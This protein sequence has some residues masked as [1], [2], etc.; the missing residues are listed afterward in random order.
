MKENLKKNTRHGITFLM[1]YLTVSLMACKDDNLSSG[2]NPSN[3]V[4]ITKIDPEEGGVGTQCLIYG[5]NFGTDISKIE[6]TFNGKKANIVG[7]D[8]DCV[9]CFVPVRAGSGPIKVRVGDKENIQEA[10]A[11]SE[12]KYTYAQRVSTLCGYSDKNGK[13]EIKDGKLSE[14]GFESPY[15]MEI[16]KKTGDLY[17]L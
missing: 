1:L 9:Y 7:S 8:G 2:Y 5:K 15:W 4:E 12:F 3:P 16:D 14:A 6:V 11:D 13:S 10:T 17:L